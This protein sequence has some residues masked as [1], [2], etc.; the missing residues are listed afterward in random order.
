[1]LSQSLNTSFF[2]SLL[3]I[4][5]VVVWVLVGIYAV[6]VY[7]TTLNRR[8]MRYAV[9]QLLSYRILF[10]MLIAMSISMLSAALVFVQPWAISSWRWTRRP[11]PRP[12]WR[13]AVSPG[14]LSHRLVATGCSGP[15]RCDVCP[16]DLRPVSPS[17]CEPRRVD[18]EG[19]RRSHLSSPEVDS[20]SE[21]V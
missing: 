15:N 1:M 6:S 10:P 5:A 11:L 2:D 18:F 17:R 7:I 8:G 20:D 3:Y 21:P 4:C 9:L 13:Q 16:L 14:L 19:Q 12:A